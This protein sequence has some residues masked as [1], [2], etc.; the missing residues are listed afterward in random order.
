MNCFIEITMSNDDFYFCSFSFSLFV[1]DH[2]GLDKNGKSKL[3]FADRDSVENEK[4][5]LQEIPLQ[6]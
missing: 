1:F 4:T 5:D 2:F 3:M 6:V